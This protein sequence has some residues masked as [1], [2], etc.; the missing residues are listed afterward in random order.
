MLSFNYFLLLCF[1]FKNLDLLDRHTTQFDFSLSTLFIIFTS[2]VLKLSAQP[3]FW[4]RINVFSTLWITVE[5]TLIWR[6]KW[7][8]IQ[9]R[10]FNVAKVSP[11]G[12]NNVEKALCQRCC[13]VAST[14]AKLNL[15]GYISIKLYWIQS[16]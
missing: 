11:R 4:R 2:C 14:S 12:W 3:T 16:S 5:I 9:S 1:C 10:I 6:W 13:N 7:N 8:K 15:L